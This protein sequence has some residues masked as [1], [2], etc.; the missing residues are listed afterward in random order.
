MFFS[1]ELRVG[2][3]DRSG[4]LL[5]AFD[6]ELDVHPAQVLPPEIVQRR[7]LVLVVRV[8]QSPDGEFAAV[9]VD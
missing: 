5:A 3:P 9:S 2:R 6:A 7:E 1:P 4:C 8:V